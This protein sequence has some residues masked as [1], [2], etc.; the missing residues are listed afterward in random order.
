MKLVFATANKA[1]LKEASE[2]LGDNYEIVSLEDMGITEDI[3][4][5]G[6]N[7]KENSLIKANY[8]YQ[9][10]AVN[11]FADD[12]GLEIDILG[13]APGV[14]SARYASMDRPSPD[15]NMDKA[16]REMSRRIS[17]AKC[18]TEL[19]LSMKIN[20]K[21]RFKTVITLI[22]NGEYHLFEGLVEGSIAIAKSGSKGFGYDPIFIPDYIPDTQGNLIE[23]KLRL[24]MS[25][26]SPNDKNL[27]SHRGRA[28]RKMAE[29]IHSL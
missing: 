7:L 8:L 26:L 23:N 3:I 24:T 4:E 14:Y 15:D 11:C 12:T 1:K 13:G 19:G 28:I 25:E 29:Y 21:A 2:I 6:T 20:R 10:Y 16:L 27:I 17:E 5:N 9:R 22:I 18:A